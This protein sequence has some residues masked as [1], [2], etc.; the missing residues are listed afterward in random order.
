LSAGNPHLQPEIGNRIELAYNKD[1]ANLGSFLVSLFY[2]TSNHDIQPYTVY[3]ADLP[4]G[5]TIYTNVAFSTR[6]NIGLEKNLGSNLFA[7]IHINQ[8]LDLRANIFLFYRRTINALNPGYNASSF[9]YRFNLNAS[10]QFPHNLAAEFFGNFNSA[11]N[12]VQGRYPSYTSYSVAFR[13]LFWNKKGSLA[14]TANNF[15]SEYVNQRT[16]IAGPGFSLNSLR[17]VPY[18]SIGLNFTWKFGVL[19]F[20]EKKEDNSGSNQPAE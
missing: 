13:K 11:R 5:D 4:I 12:E 7:D 14:L 17:Q 20:K 2:R 8:K 3:Y 6:Q 19:E 16:S 10:Y 9:N 18:R 15:L 1:L